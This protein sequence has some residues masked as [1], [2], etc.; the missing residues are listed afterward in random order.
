MPCEINRSLTWEIEKLWEVCQSLQGSAKSLTIKKRVDL[1]VER[2]QHA[3]ICPKCRAVDGVE[4]DNLQ[5][6][7]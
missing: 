2:D 5:D 4:E 3:Q 7:G 6:T 1:I